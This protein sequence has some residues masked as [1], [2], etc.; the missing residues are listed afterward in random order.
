V[1]HGKDGRYTNPNY[2]CAHHPTADWLP[3]P[4]V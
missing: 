2:K 1:Y 4:K 3:F